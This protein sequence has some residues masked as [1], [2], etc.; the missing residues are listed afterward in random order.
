MNQVQ[1]PI[2]LLYIVNPHLPSSRYCTSWCACS[3]ASMGTLPQRKR[4]DALPAVSTCH[5]VSKAKGQNI[6][7]H[8]Q[9]DTEKSSSAFCTS[10]NSAASFKAAA[11]AAA[12]ASDAPRR[13]SPISIHRRWSLR[14]G[15]EKLLF[16]GVASRKLQFLAQKGMRDIFWPYVF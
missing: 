6:P 3:V 1:L 14:F 8:L 4:R 9:Q 13:W 11:A 15:D 12:D 10:P 2:L 7:K 5:K 16:F